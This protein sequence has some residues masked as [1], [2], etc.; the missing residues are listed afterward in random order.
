MQ[1]DFAE[2]V[3]ESV[4]SQVVEVDAFASVH[5]MIHAAIASFGTQATLREVQSSTL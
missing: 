3:S 1:G 5:D 4:A 2:V